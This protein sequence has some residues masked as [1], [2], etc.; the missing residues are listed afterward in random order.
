MTKV[1]PNAVIPQPA[2][3]TA[4]T[5]GPLVLTIWKKSLLF[6]CHGFTV[7]DSNGNLVYRV[8]NYAAGTKAEI[9]LMD[10]TGRSLLTLRRKRLSLVDNWTVYDGET[11]ANPKF[12]VTKHVNLLNTKSIAHVNI[13]GSKTKKPVYEIEG[14]YTQ[15]CCVVYDEK[16][17]HVAEINRKEAVGGVKFGGDVFRLVVQPEIDP[18]VAMALVIILDQMFQ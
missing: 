2:T 6:N 16:R 18:T 4:P 1:Y 15:R 5:R 13:T 9:L 3:V 10:A 11:A 17:R 12:T 14:S 8:D 7:F